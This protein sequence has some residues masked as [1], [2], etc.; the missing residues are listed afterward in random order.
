MVLGDHGLL[1]VGESLDDTVLEALGK[2]SDEDTELIT[3][4]YGAD[5]KMEDAETLK[6]KAEER[7]PDAEIELNAGGQ[8]VY[9]YLISVE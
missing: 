8:P 3:L 5:V 2:I 4:Y 6:E 7:F 1:T 9:Y